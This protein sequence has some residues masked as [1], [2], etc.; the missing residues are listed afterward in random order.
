MP[1]SID[2]EGALR[3]LWRRVQLVIGR[4][5]VTFSDDSGNVQRYQ[6]RL[7]QLEIRDSTARLAEFGFTSRP[8]VGSDV[9]VLFP[10][11]DRTNAVV[12]ATGHQE[13]RPRG[14]Q[15]G[16]SQV[17]DQWGKYLYFTKDGGIVVEAQGTP[18]TVN[19]AT[20]VTINASDK[21]LMNTPLL[22]V[23]GDIKAGGQVSDQVRSMAADRQIYDSH[24]HGGGPTPDQQQ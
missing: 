6:V 12:V 19:N 13:T 9:V 14:L 17:Y 22:E 16:E 10:A 24:A 7:G 18:V 15:E 1:P 4:G 2:T 8:P 20:T 3:R 21:V 5:R 11:G 23:S